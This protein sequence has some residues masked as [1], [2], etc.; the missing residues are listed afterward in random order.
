MILLL[1]ALASISFLFAEGAEPIQNI[2]QFFNIHS[3]AEFK[4][5][6]QYFFIKL[7]NCSLCCGFWIGLFFTHSIFLAA[8]VS[9]LSEYISKQ[10]R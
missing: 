1:I 4:N 2:K 8:I 6:Y 3:D 7:L 9:V 5:K 10:L